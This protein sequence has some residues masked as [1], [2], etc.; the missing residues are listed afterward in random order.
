MVRDLAAHGFEHVLQGLP[1]G[2][3]ISLFNALGHGK[4]ARAVDPDEKIELALG[5]LHFCDINVKEPDPVA[6]ELLALQLVP[7]QIRQARNAMLLQRRCSAECVSCGIDGC[8]AKRQSSSG[9][10]V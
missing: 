1:S 4:F 9:S 5:R 3:A 10:S 2:V 8:R 6:L 7:C